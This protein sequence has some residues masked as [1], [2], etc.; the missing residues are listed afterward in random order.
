MKED[1][2]A[3]VKDRKARERESAT[4]ETNRHKMKERQTHS[5][6]KKERKKER[7]ADVKDRKEKKRVIIPRKQFYLYNF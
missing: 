4:K 3:D 6:R 1:R 5:E 2:P 7:P